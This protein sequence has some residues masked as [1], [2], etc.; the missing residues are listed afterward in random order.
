MSPTVAHVLLGVALL[1]LA[2]PTSDPPLPLLS[3]PP[4]PLS[5]QERGNEVTA[6]LGLPG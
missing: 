5:L 2:Q 1:L 3:S 6:S 4:D